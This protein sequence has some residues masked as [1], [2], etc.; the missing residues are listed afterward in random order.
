M[1]IYDYIKKNKD[2][3]LN[4]KNF[5]E[6]DN[7]IFSILSYLNFQEVLYENNKL[8]T[9]A[10][11]FFKKY[12]KKEIYKQGIPQKDAYKCLEKIYT[13]ERYKDV[14]IL[15]YIYIGTQNEQF[16][17]ITFKINKKL[18]Y[19]SFEGTD[20]LMSGWK[21]DFQLAYTYPIPSQSRAKK[22]LNENVK[23]F[24]PKII[25][26]GHSKGGNLALT[27]AMEL[28]IIKKFKIKKIYNNDGPGLRYKE[29]HSLKYKMIKKKYIKIIPYNS[30]IGI[31]LRNE[32]R[33]VVESNRKTILSHYPI[34]WMIKENKFIETKQ[35]SK[36]IE[37]EE[38][39]LMWLDN[40][41]DESRKKMIDNVFKIFEKCEINDTRDMKKLKNIIK[42]IKELKNIDEETKELLI[43]FLS[44]TIFNKKYE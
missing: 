7:I 1:K 30:I 38:N 39:M 31:M 3:K 28:N 12:T 34:S 20:N 15:N 4:E 16:S 40:H 11:L 14:E 9:I 6:V 33:K 37:L 27:S 23:I 8:E 19:I 41:N 43:D 25:V 26:G 22:F 2:A 32:N 35:K 29:F 36:S 42:I 13:T 21:E 24:G 10:Q 44:C 18:I 17:A 5:N